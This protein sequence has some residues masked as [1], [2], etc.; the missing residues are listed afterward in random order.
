MSAPELA[1]KPNTITEMGAEQP[2]V[3]GAL[4]GGYPP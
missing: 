4:N 2:F 3:D 1:S